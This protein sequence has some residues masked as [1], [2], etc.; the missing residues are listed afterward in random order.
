MSGIVRDYTI[1]FVVDTSQ[2]SGLAT[3]EGML[4]SIEARTLGASQALGNLG[5]SLTNLQPGATAAGNLNAGLTNVANSAGKAQAAI[6]GVNNQLGVLSLGASGAGNSINVTAQAAGG[7]QK[8]FMGLNLEMLATAAAFRGL[9]FGVAIVAEIGRGAAEA[10]KHLAELAED[11]TKTRDAMRELANLR[12]HS[13]PD[14]EV[15]SGAVAFGLKANMTPDQARKFLERFEGSVPAGEQ[16]GNIGQIEDNFGILADPRRVKKTKEEIALEAAKF[17][18]RVNLEDKTAGDIAGVIPMYKRVT[19]G[20]DMA[21]TLGRI[22]YGLN[23]GRGNLEPLMRGLTETAGALVDQE[24]GP[25]S[26]PE[27]LAV[28]YGVMSTHKGEQAS[29]TYLR[30]AVR[31]LSDFGGKQEAG[32]RA[33]GITEKDSALQK[34]RKADQYLRKREQ[35]TGLD[36]GAL[37]QQMG[38]N[39]GAGREAVTMM[40]RDMPVV[41]QRL[42]K[43]QGITGTQVMR[44]NEEYFLK[45]PAG[46]RQRIEAAAQASNYSRG[47]EQE[48]VNNARKMAVVRMKEESRFMSGELAFADKV[49]ELGGATTAIAGMPT[50]LENRINDEAMHNLHVAATGA[51]LEEHFLRMQRDKAPMDQIFREM[52]PRIQERGVDPFQAPASIRLKTEAAA[53]PEA[54]KKKDEAARRGR[55]AP[56]LDQEE[57]TLRKE[58]LGSKTDHR[59][60]RERM[61][62][63]LDNEAL[64]GMTPNRA[65]EHRIKGRDEN[66]GADGPQDMEPGVILGPRPGVPHD[67]ISDA[68]AAGGGTK[69]PVPGHASTGDAKTHE[70][71]GQVV[72]VMNKVA[73]GI[74]RLDAGDSGGFDLPDRPGAGPMRA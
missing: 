64:N 36:R 2:A 30:K 74:E 55:N 28:L 45:N 10:R 73:R 17:G 16:K 24:H 42:I 58:R 63:A 52:V 70:L 1:A 35:E 48:W 37:L 21:Q 72:A 44:Q 31:E 67:R 65:A 59:S 15:T 56:T 25:V 43:Q 12:G 19:G 62:D 22:A 23:E 54:Q 46:V 51:G 57:I 61:L 34:F 71:L 5:Q 4:L 9:E 68:A 8:S 50:E 27:E 33:M 49:M 69:P 14:D 41:E 29:G 20:L 7:A 47:R 11:A 3:I 13:G 6:Q 53:R 38:F 60:F 39:E 40:T 66:P 32:L 26:S 18:K